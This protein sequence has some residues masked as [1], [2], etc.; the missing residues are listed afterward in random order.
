[1]RIAV[2]GRPLAHP[3]TGIGRYLSGILNAIERPGPDLLLLG[4]ASVDSKVSRVAR[5]CSAF[6]TYGLRSRRLNADVYWSPRHHLPA[7]LGAL[8]AV[9][10]IHDLVWKHA[11]ETMEPGRRTLERILMTHAVRAARKIIVVSHATRDD[12][13][14]TFP[15][16]QA[17]VSVIHPGTSFQPPI[18]REARSERPYALFVGTMEPRKNL[19]R[20]LDAFE[21]ARQHGLDDYD[22]VIVGGEGWKHRDLKARLQRSPASARI[23]VAGSVSDEHLAE[24]YASADFLMA[25]SLYEGFGMQILEALSS[26]VPVITSEVSSMPEVC[27]DAG[28]KVDPTNTEQIEGAMLRLANDRDLRAR[29]ADNARRQAEQFCWHRAASRTIDLLRSVGGTFGR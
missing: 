12:L 8:P 27:G 6:A 3:R 13:L 9:V 1:M 26:G 23:K 11:P 22:L 5:L 28:L 17:K 16:A 14:R 7:M 10:T 18:D 19:T 24:L 25:P 4:S 29:L 21:R 15:D 20:V 2:D